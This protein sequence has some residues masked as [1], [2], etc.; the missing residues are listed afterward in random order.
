MT[1]FSGEVYERFFEVGL[2]LI[3]IADTEGYFR[4]VNLSFSKVLGFSEE[5]L[6][7]KPIAEFLH[8]EDI[9]ITDITIATLAKGVVIESFVNRFMCKSGGYRW[10]RWSVVPETDTGLL[11]CM[12]IDVTKEKE[13]ELELAS[14]EKELSLI[15]NNVPLRIWY[16]DDKNNII[17]LN[18]MAARSMNMTVEEA[19][20]KN[21][22]DLFP[23]IAEAY[24]KDDLQVIR[25]GK[26][27]LGYIEAYKPVDAEPGWVRTDKMP[28]RANGKN[29]VFVVSQDVTE[30]VNADI[31]L[32]ENE[33]R[34][35]SVFDHTFDYIN[36]MDASGTILDMNRAAEGFSKEQVIGLNLISFFPEQEQKKLIKQKLEKAVSTGEAQMYESYLNVDGK[37]QYYSTILSPIHNADGSVET[38]SSISRDITEQKENEGRL[39][40]LN[41]DLE[42]KIRERTVDLEEKNLEL[43]RAN[44]YLDE[45][46]Y[47]AA[48]DLRSPIIA[49]SSLYKIYNNTTN[50]ERK[51]GAMQRIGTSI[52]QLQDTLD[53]LI[54]II[55]LKGDEST[56]IELVDV[57]KMIDDVVQIYAEKVNAT[58]AEVRTNLAVGELR[59]VKVYLLSVLQNLISNAIKYRDRSRTLEI[60]ISTKIEDGRIVFRVSDNGMGIDLDRFREKMFQ[61]FQRLTDVAEGKGIGL[62]LVKRI[63]EKNEGI[64]EVESELGKGTTF[65]ISFKKDAL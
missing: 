32:R 34:L 63:V 8:P 45:F 43:E 29:F 13:Y 4:K 55:D 58:G 47:T 44:S 23:E 26:P 5:E 60:D 46:V 33:E 52:Q 35:R 42:L 61:P 21:T 1:L 37:I 50:A 11:Y 36:L 28:Y 7:T 56:E 41:D 14:K 18:E 51:E 22:K 17:R 54:H 62:N 10:L 39:K 3:C 24:H 6:L 9:A 15:F 38:L 31:M 57:Q 12:A 16:K 53:G 59:F 20:G 25:S 48:H 19:E 65:V 30:Q 64:I 49:I 27:K 40:Q 2:G